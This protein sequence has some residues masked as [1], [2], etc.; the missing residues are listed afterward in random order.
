MFLRTGKRKAACG[1]GCKITKIPS[2]DET[3][4]CRNPWVLFQRTQGSDGQFSFVFQLN[5]LSLLTL[6]F[7]NL[8]FNGFNQVE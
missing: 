4:K 2:F 7:I 8:L 5:D 3:A 1:I 6:F